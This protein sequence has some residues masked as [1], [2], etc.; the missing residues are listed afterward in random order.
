MEMSS[1]HAPLLPRAAHHTAS[2]SATSP[3]KVSDMHELDHAPPNAS[4]STLL[5]PS[6]AAALPARNGAPS[7]PLPDIPLQEDL[8]KHD[9]Q[10]VALEHAGVDATAQLN[11]H[12]RPVPPH[13]RTSRS[14]SDPSW[15]NSEHDIQLAT[16]TRAVS[17]KLDSLPVPSA[18]PPSPP[19]LSLDGHIIDDMQQ[20]GTPLRFAH[21]TSGPPSRDPPSVPAAGPSLRPI[22][23]PPMPDSPPPSIPKAHS[24]PSTPDS[25]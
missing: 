24:S 10:I 12:L 6:K 8:E 9:T 20:N 11:G 25:H 1:L 7:P 3:R 15:P 13:L 14:P 22:S 5:E 23:H 2:S 21:A 16:P 19:V 18:A 4:S 17:M